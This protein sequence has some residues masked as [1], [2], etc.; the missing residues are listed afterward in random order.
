MRHA[1]RTAAGPRRLRAAELAAATVRF[2]QVAIAGGSVFASEGRP[3]EGG[4]NVVVECSATALHDLNP[5]PFDARTRVHE[6]GGG[7]FVV[8]DDGE[9]FF[10]H[11]ADQRIWR[12]RRGEAPRPV[13]RGDALRY[14]DAAARCPPRPARRGA[15]GSLG[16]RRGGRDDRRDRARV[17]RRDRAGERP[18]LL[19]RARASRP[20][21][22]AWPG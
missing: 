2:G 8:A 12:M 13:T 17:G 1:P 11:D 15:R 22:A 5:A 3:A 6:Y 18:R 16:R 21:A 4:R 14:A 19:L 9:L 20:T 7:A 10:S